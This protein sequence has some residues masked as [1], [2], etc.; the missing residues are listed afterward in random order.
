MD[1]QIGKAPGKHL[2][3]GITIIEL[4]QMFPDNNT[5]EQ[6]FEDCRWG[7]DRE[8]LSCPKCHGD[9]VKET[10]KRKPLP[11]WCSDCR[12][13]FSFKGGTIMERSRISHQKWAIA[14]YMWVTSLKGVS[15]MK[16]H[17]ELGIT[18]KSAYFMA[19]RLREAS[20]VMNLPTSGPVEVDEVYIGGKRKNMANSKRKELK[21]TG[22]GATGKVAVV[23]MK[24]RVTGQVITEVVESTDAI[25]LQSFVKH[26]A[27]EG[28]ALYTDEALAYKGI[29]KFKH[30][31]VR[32]SVS[33]FVRD[34]AHTN[35]I[36]S[37]WS[38]CIT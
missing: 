24:D 4:F 3:K 18:Q 11:Y 21:E 14:I 27:L 30:E 13:H 1:E 22:R 23:G 26:N 37:F 7:E 19:Q 38:L 6:W 20:N 31:S 17:R 35:C 29:S 32:H 9:H 33:E 12:R 10:P 25:T 28:A 36:E 2:R 16:L 34:K 8:Y 5:A 15:S